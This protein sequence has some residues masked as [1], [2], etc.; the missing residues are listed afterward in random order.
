M[1]GQDG[2]RHKLKPFPQPPHLEG[3]TILFDY[4]TGTVALT[5]VLFVSNISGEGWGCSGSFIAPGIPLT[6]GSCKGISVNR[7]GGRVTFSNTV[8]EN[9]SEPPAKALSPITLNGT[10]TFPPF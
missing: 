2:R 7:S 10:L 5:G 8:L 6:N 1:E 4:E 9:L 3:L